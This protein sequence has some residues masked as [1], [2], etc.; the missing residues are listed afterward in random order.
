MKTYL[1]SFALGEGASYDNVKEVLSSYPKWARV[2]RTTWMVQT[3][4]KAVDIRSKLSN[5]M[6]KHGVVVVVDIS[7]K[8]WA[9]Y[10]VGKNVTNWMRENI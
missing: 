7:H 4:D 1:V 2:M 3:D 5:A 8:G 10:A 6:D 9:T